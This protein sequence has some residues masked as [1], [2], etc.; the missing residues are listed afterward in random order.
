MTTEDQPLKE[1]CKGVAKLWNEL[2][3]DI[4]IKYKDPDYIESIRGDVP[5]V[6]VNGQIQTARK[7]RVANTTLYLGSNK[8][9]V[10]FV[11]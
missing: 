4:K 9:S 2:D 6:V 1:R 5:I 3:P 10:S 8:P 11:K 7:T